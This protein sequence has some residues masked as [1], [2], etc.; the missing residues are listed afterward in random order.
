MLK[1]VAMALAVALGSAV[2]GAIAM[3]LEGAAFALVYGGDVE[4]GMTVFLAQ[5][6]TILISA[7]VAALLL[8]LFV[9][10]PASLALRRLAREPSQAYLT[11]GAV[12]GVLLAAA[13]DWET[14]T[15]DTLTMIWFATWGVITAALFWIAFRR[16]PSP[17]PSPLPAA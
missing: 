9:L 11:L 3:F 6:P 1:W 17:A 8:V 12:V 14:G 2:L 7:F 13:M 4:G 16:Q 5:L 15:L 10:W